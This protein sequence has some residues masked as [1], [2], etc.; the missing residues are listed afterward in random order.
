[1]IASDVSRIG[2]ASLTPANIA[3][4]VKTS[5]GDDKNYDYDGYTTEEDV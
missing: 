5:D 1:M 3:G 2:S 4:L